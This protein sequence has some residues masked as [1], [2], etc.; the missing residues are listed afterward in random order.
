MKQKVFV[1]F[2]LVFV[3]V[4][5]FSQ[6]AGD[7][8][9]KQSGNWGSRLNWQRY[10]TTDPA[11]WK[12][13]DAVLYPFNFPTNLN[14]VITIQEGHRITLATSRTADQVIIRGTLY[15][16]DGKI[17]TINDGPGTDISV[18]GVLELK[19]YII[20][21]GSI[22]VTGAMLDRG[23][24]I[25]GS[26][27]YE[28]SSGASIEIQ[29]SD[30]LSLVE[31]DEA[32][33]T[34]Y[35][36]GLI[37]CEGGI[38]F[39]ETA[40]YMFYGYGPQNQV[41]NGLPAVV[42][43]IVINHTGGADVLLSSDLTVT[44]RFTYM[45]GEF[46][47]N[48]FVLSYAPG[49]TLE[50]AAN[51]PGQDTDDDCFP[52]TYGPT[53][54]IIDNSYGV[55]LHA[56]RSISGNLFLTNGAF[57]LSGYVFTVNGTTT[58]TGG[59][60]SGST[61]VTDGYIDVAQYI[62]VAE[63]NVTV[64]NLSVNTI[65]D[66]GTMGRAWIISGTT[67]SDKIITF[68]W[69][70]I[71]DGGFPWTVSNQPSIF[72]NG[73]KYFGTYDVSGAL[74]SL[75]ISNI[76]V[77]SSAQTYSSTSGEGVTL[78]VELSSFTAVF[79]TEMYVQIDWLVESETNHS[80]YNVLRSEIRDLDTALRVN[81][82]L[83][84]GGTEL[85]TQISYSFKDNEVDNNTNYYYWLE[86]VALD[87]STEYAGPLLV[88]VIA[89]GETPGVPQI[90]VSTVLMSAYPNPFNPQ[91]SLRYSL[92]EAGNV[93]IDVYNVKGQIIRSFTKNH[94]TPGYFSVT[95]DGKDNSG[96]S[97]SSGV[98]FYRMISGKYSA[99]RKMMLMK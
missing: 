34:N 16:E 10:Y 1:L 95:W 73:T 27:N 7:Y 45:N 59:S 99:I 47:D 90:P 36:Y 50:Y 44:T 69:T 98:Y 26:G 18:L 5:L 54:V 93:T 82:E 28:L 42:N 49:A 79:N 53:N 96:S 61:L 14:G 84:A 68:Y 81:S 65:A 21:N 62:S 24:N 37:Q 19:G 29:N 8:R 31:Y 48:T 67:V 64:T 91:T 23:G 80:G 74:N 75:R 25:N 51:V 6:N 43:S 76:P 92:K 87:G 13:Y 63:N 32:E 57:A 77:L 39:S 78:P 4:G 88:S 3:C 72:L 58:K 38:V 89:S 46:K 60:V 83:I 11:G 70:D 56:N 20:N 2:L 86:S 33:D 66:S 85:G 15:I 40:N 9:S 41:A 17:L 30:G 94:A 52:A 97:V 55:S 35:Y 12:N 22:I 71:D